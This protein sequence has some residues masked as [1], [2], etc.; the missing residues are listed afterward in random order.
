M[1]LKNSYFDLKITGLLIVTGGSRSVRTA[2][3]KKRRIREAIDKSELPGLLSDTG[4]SG[5]KSLRIPSIR[6]AVSWAVCDFRTLVRLLLRTAPSK[7][8][9]DISVSETNR[10]KQELV[11]LSLRYYDH[12]RSSLV[13]KMAAVSISI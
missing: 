2:N 13:T 4:G 6:G 5:G 11:P 7:S 3:K 1:C 9:E 10:R 12:Y 8:D